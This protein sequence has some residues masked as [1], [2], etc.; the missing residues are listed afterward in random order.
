MNGSPDRNAPVRPAAW[1]TLALPADARSNGSSNVNGGVHPALLLCLLF[2]AL[3]S[4]A[5]CSATPDPE[6]GS[7]VLI[8]GLDGAAPRL[9]EPMLEAGR[10]PNLARIAE[11]GVHGTIRSLRPIDSPLIWNTVVT[12]KRPEAHGILSFAPP[13]VEGEPRRLYLSS[14]RKVHA[15]WNI[16]SGLG[17]SSG[18]VNFWNTYP[19]EKIEGVMVS[20]HLLAQ[21]V[22]GRIA[23][24][25]A[26]AVP[27][28]PV[29]FPEAWHERLLALMDG[30]GHTRL[31]EFENP[32]RDNP[33]LPEYLQL[34][35]QSLPR[36]FEEDEALTRIALEI[37]EA[38]D[39]QLMMVLLP[40]IDRVSHFLWSGMEDPSI[41]DEELRISPSEALAARAALEHY[42]EF[43]DALVGLLVA[44][45]GPDD[46][47]LVMSDHGFEAGR[48]MGLLTGVHEGEASI[49]GIFFARGRGI[50]PGQPVGALS[51]ADVTP[52]VLAWWG[53]PEA[54]DMDGRPASFLAAEDLEG[55]EKVATYDTTV[56]ERL[57]FSASGAEPELVERLRSLGYIE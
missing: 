38:L 54:E 5:G 14:D 3:V 56:I 45:M 49:D 50:A 57:P 29:I 26:E 55:R 17:K 20:D 13:K 31:T 22:K 12:G 42:Y 9:V 19:P 6:S 24:A 1:T 4:A 27:A 33:A 48:G 21:Q 10:L 8:I 52:T 16:A 28:G 53:L 7:R 39:P 34:A 30:E 47:V 40:G 15:L 18:V 41:Y 2:A 25:K 46:L 11:T 37:G 35:G 44:R 51:V 23:L 36:R 32:L 43:A